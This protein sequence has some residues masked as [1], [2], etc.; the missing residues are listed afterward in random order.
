G[1]VLSKIF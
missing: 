1:K